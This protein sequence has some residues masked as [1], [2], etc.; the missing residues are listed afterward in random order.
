[1]GRYYPK[2]VVV[3]LPNRGTEIRA[4]SACVYRSPSVAYL[5]LST[6]RLSC[7]IGSFAHAYASGESGQERGGRGEGPLVS[8]LVVG[9]TGLRARNGVPVRE[10]VQRLSVDVQL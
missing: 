2:P 7:V 8:P 4:A 10:A 5:Y 9:H 3:P 6:R 1:M